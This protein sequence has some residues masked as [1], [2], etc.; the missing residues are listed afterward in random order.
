LRVG[1]VL[2]ESAGPSAVGGSIVAI[3]DPDDWNA[4]GPLIA[5]PAAPAGVAAAA[6][7][8]KQRTPMTRSVRCFAR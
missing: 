6:I 5:A 3:V 4:I 1:R 7:A 8:D 2:A